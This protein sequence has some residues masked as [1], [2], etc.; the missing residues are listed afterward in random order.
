VNSGHSQIAKLTKKQWLGKS[1]GGGE[2]GVSRLV[3]SNKC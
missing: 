3:Q 1:F 2:V